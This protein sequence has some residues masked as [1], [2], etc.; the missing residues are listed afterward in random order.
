[1][2][3]VIAA[4]TASPL[5]ELPDWLAA[6]IAASMPSITGIDARLADST[7]RREWFWVMWAISCAVTAASSSSF[8][9]ISTMPAKV[10][11]KPPGAA[12]ALIV[13]S[14]IRKNLK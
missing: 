13:R 9:T 11:M 8:S 7:P 12:K 2:P 4:C 3:L 10:P 14:R 6:T 5:E 1:M